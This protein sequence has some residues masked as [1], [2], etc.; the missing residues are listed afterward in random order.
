MHG[1]SPSS[2]TTSCSSSSLEKTSPYLRWCPEGCSIGLYKADMLSR[3]PLQDCP[4]RMSLPGKIVLMME[5]LQASPMNFE[6]IRT[7][8]S[9]YKTLSPCFLHHYCLQ[10]HTNFVECLQLHCFMDCCSYNSL[11]CKRRLYLE[12]KYKP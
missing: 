10:T 8:I 7:C 9:Y 4:S 11:T 5:M 6:H 3:L 12:T 1:N 2:L